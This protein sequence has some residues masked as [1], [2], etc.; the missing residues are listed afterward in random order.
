MNRLQTCLI[1]PNQTR[2][3]KLIILMA[4]IRFSDDPI[5]FGTARI[6]GFRGAAD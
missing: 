4:R 3:V 5:P 1:V 6:D 2:S